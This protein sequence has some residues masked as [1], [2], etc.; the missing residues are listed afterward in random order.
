VSIDVFAERVLALLDGERT[1]QDVLVEA[2]AESEAPLAEFVENAIPVLRRLIEL[3]FVL[4][5][6]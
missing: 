4:P 3:G 1:L 5:T 6:P 2:A